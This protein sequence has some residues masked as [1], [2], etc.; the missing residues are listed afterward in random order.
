MMCGLMNDTEQSLLER[1]SP[2]L[3]LVIDGCFFF[4]EFHCHPTLKVLSPIEPRHCFKILSLNWWSLFNFEVAAFISTH[5]LWFKINNEIKTV[6]EKI[7]SSKWKYCK[8]ASDFCR[9]APSRYFSLSLIY[10]I[11]ENRGKLVRMP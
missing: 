10:V 1:N 8:S 9:M 11:S 5:C 3:T 4:L 7:V 6:H 2:E